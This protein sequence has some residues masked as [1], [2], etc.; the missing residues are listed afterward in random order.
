MSKAVCANLSA[1]ERNSLALRRLILMR[2]PPAE[3]LTQLNE[4]DRSDVRRK[5]RETR[6]CATIE[7]YSNALD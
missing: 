1:H 6:G 4:D 3:D 7:A 2:R 5:R